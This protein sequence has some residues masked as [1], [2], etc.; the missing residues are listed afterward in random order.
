MAQLPLVT[1]LDRLARS[2]RELL[3]PA[4]AD[5]RARHIMLFDAEGEPRPARDSG[6]APIAPTFFSRWRLETRSS[7]LPFHNFLRADAGRDRAKDSVAI[8][9]A[10][11]PPLCDPVSRVTISSLLSHVLFPAAGAD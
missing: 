8:F 9:V 11:S 1:C 5:R 2:T 4:D 10:R 3:H 7:A 6:P